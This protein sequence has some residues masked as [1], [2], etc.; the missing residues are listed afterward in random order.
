[1]D[2][3]LLLVVRL[4]LLEL[5]RELEALV[6]VEEL[7]VDILDVVSNVLEVFEELDVVF[8]VLDVIFDVLDVVR[9]VLVVLLVEVEEVVS[10]LIFTVVEELGV[11]TLDFP[12]EVVVEPV[13]FKEDE[14]EEVVALRR[15]SSEPNPY[16]STAL[17]NPY[18]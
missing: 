14:G 3:L 5:E 2:L 7:D 6:F 8:D 17:P 4:E 12:V 10:A 1:V 13:F 16:R 15:S 11:L 9:D 18:V